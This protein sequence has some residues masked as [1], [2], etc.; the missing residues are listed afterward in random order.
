MKRII[1]IIFAIIAVITT[2]NSYSQ[3]LRSLHLHSSKV[4]AI[5]I[6]KE[7]VNLSIRKYLNLSE[8]YTFKK[9][10]TGQNLKVQKDML[11]HSHERY[12][13]YYK[14][15]KIENSDIRVHF[16]NNKCY[17]LN[18][19]Y[20]DCSLI[21]TSIFISKT[22]A[23]NR[24]KFFVDYYYSI[25]SK[26]LKSYYAS[27]EIV[28]CTNQM[29]D[30]DTLLH[31]A[32]KIDLYSTGQLFHEFIFVDG[33]TGEILNH[34]SLIMNDNGIAS[35]R[36]S[37]D[38]TIATK[39]NSSYNILHDTTRGNGIRTYNLNHSTSLSSAV[40]FTD[41]DNN[42]TSA[43]FHNS[44]KDDG[45][46]DAHWGAMMTYDYFKQVH[47]RNSYDN[48][49][50]AITNYVHYGT[51]YENAFWSQSLNSMFYGDG[52]NNYDIFTSLDVIGHEIAH[53][54]CQYSADLLYQG[55]SGAINEALSDI[56]AACIEEWATT[57]KQTWLVGEDL[58][59]PI[60]SMSDPNLYSCP[61][62]YKGNYWIPTNSN[63][64]FG[65]VHHNSGVIN[66]WFYLLTTGG[67]GTNDNGNYYTVTG[68]GIDHASQIVYRA[69][70]AYMTSNTDFLKAKE[71][72]I[73]AAKD[74][75]GI[76]SDEVKAVRDA[77]YA[78]GVYTDL[79]IR[80]AVDD[81]GSMPSTV[82]ENWNSPD[83]WIEDLS[84]NRVE[85]PAGNTE[86]KVCVRIRNKS[87]HA[88]SGNERLFINWAKA[89]IND[90]WYENWTS[91]NFLSCNQ[92][93]GGTI[94]SPNGILLPVIPANGSKVL[95]VSWWTP[96]GEDY[97]DCHSFTEDPWH[98][99]LLARVHDDDTIAHENEQQTGVY[100]LVR[101]HN[102]VAQRNVYLSKSVS[103]KSVVSISNPTSNHITRF[104]R[105]IKRNNIFE[106][107][108]TNFAEISLKL[109]A[110]LISS[111]N[112]DLLTGAKFVNDNTLLITDDDFV[113]PLQLAAGQYSTLST[114][115]NF[116]TNKYP[117]NDTTHFDIVA[118]TDED[119]YEIASGQG[120]NSIYTAGRTFHANAGNDTSVLLN[121]TATLHAAQIN[122][123][124]TCRWYDKQRNF[125]YEGLNYTVTP[126]ETNEY[127]LEVT[128]ESDGYRDL[129]TVKVNVVP[130]CI[131]SITPNPVGSNWVV[132]SYEYAAT[133]TSAQLLVYNTATATLVGNYDLSNLDN[134]GSVNV[135]VANY[136]AGS[137]TVVLMC[138]NA[139]CH[140]KVLIRQ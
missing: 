65:G 106:E 127:I 134:A 108:I 120:F 10:E 24:A 109:D 1:K 114:S 96:R 135:E 110:D 21:D 44:N 53:G 18:G 83:I 48:N 85:N 23:I 78:V 139:V 26:T 11:G 45:A 22:S 94:G 73:E 119:F 40:D 107:K 55:E 124:A 128:A 50:S 36:Y 75:Y 71:Y 90:Y 13:Q 93:K 12:V 111:I 100:W 67:N 103:Y 43:E 20:A 5:N 123:D 17:A 130:G 57:G 91:Y 62:T 51:D 61:N 137:Y 25:D 52:Y 38:R 6:Q 14:G 68:I 31:I 132:V 16:S 33:K 98:F 72:T 80:D 35:T 95:K 92:Y 70:T 86:Y 122:E 19:E 129:D 81:D 118:F 136:P 82:A 140:S 104:L 64:D 66:Y 7:N 56:W 126:S 69:E 15:I 115:V 46:L 105:L 42:W 125:K 133:V 89:G 9:K 59:S 58:G 77:W 32:Y 34:L 41:Y 54:V 116:F 99:C 2:I 131:R 60:R 39:L 3:E 49:N 76:S 138:D 79:Y 84:G 101:D 121:T 113:L 102:N 28:I 29:I 30:D 37:G 88:S 27:P 74:L 47:G 4:A 87:K 63:S 112:Y 8:N 117:Q 97:E